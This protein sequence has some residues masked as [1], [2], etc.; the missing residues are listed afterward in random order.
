MFEKLK[1]CSH[2][3]GIGSVAYD[4]WSESGAWA[5]VQCQTCK[6][7]TESCLDISEA[8]AA[9]NNRPIEDKLQAR[10]A[11]LE[12]DLKEADE[13]REILEG[14]TYHITDGRL[15]K[16][17]PLDTLKALYDDDMMACVE[18][19]TEH[20]RDR[21]DALEWLR[22]VEAYDPFTE[23]PMCIAAGNSSERGKVFARAE[24]EH[25][26]ILAAAREAVES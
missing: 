18:R 26:A 14:L 1:P 9:W 19:E 17:Y 11:K 15:S 22:E 8:I 24:A 25:E 16:V 12:A 10:I 13:V 21:I 20:L 2:C 3:E 7:C 23:H 5:C 6:I 4:G